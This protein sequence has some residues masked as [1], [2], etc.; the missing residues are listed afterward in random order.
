MNFIRLVY[1]FCFLA[2]YQ[3]TEFEKCNE[4]RKA[5]LGI[6]EGCFPDKP[7]E[8]EYIIGFEPPS[9]NEEYVT[10]E[11]STH[12]FTPHID[13]IA[14]GFSDDREMGNE[15]VTVCSFT[16]D[17]KL[18][19]LTWD[20]PIKFNIP[21]TE[22]ILQVESEKVQLLDSKKTDDRLY[23]KFKQHTN[24]GE[25]NP[26]LAD[27]S[28]QYHLLFARGPLFNHAEPRVL[29]AHSFNNNSLEFPQST[30]VKL[31]LLE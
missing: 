29:G 9:N 28:K 25:T 3:A 26:Y 10:I 8:C 27:L 21:A 31:N 22:E 17:D 4:G 2:T 16:D 6:P 20:P 23:C 19:H 30:S 24:K 11:L 7:N 13:Y 18:V 15:P 5:C 12:R 1:I 14:I